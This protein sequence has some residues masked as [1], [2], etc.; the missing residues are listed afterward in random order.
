MKKMSNPKWQPRNDC[1]GRLN[2][3]NNNSGEYGAELQ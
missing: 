3:N 1:D 2:P